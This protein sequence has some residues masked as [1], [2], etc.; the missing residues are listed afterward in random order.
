[1]VKERFIVTS[2]GDNGRYKENNADTNNGKKKFLI[3]V[4]LLLPFLTLAA[5]FSQEFY[6]SWNKAMT[7]QKLLNWWTEVQSTVCLFHFFFW[8]KQKVLSLFLNF[9]LQ[10]V[11]IKPI[12][13]AIFSIQFIHKMKKLPTVAPSFLNWRSCQISP[14]RNLSHRTKLENCTQLI[15]AKQ[16][17]RVIKQPVLILLVL[18]LSVRFR[19][20]QSN[21]VNI[22]P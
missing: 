9:H 15:L 20:C 12:Y 18:H 3:K 8:H 7:L 16:R 5:S 22:G 10:R 11:F 4:I 1:M 6:F 17:R 19:N 14:K 13:L 21:Y 2:H